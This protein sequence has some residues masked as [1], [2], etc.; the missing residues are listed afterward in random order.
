MD[1]DAFTK[2][3][4]EGLKNYDRN[5][6]FVIADCPEKMEVIAIVESL[7]SQIK[8]DV[9]NACRIK[10]G[11]LL[12]YPWDKMHFP[13]SKKDKWAVSFRGTKETFLLSLDKKGSL[14]G[15]LYSDKAEIYRTMKKFKNVKMMS[16]DE[17]ETAVKAGLLPLLA[18][19][20]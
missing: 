11:A 4:L 6:D 19:D 18:I 1:A 14:R 2:E 8:G 17:L 20:K 12:C 16:D 10:S 5:K 15:H 9:S 7:L 3:I 13:H